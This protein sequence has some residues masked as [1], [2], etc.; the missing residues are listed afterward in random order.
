MVT[1][2]ILI[3]VERSKINEVAE[4]LTE[5]NGISEVY[6]VSGNYDLIAIARVHTNEELSDLV[7]KHMH[8]INSILETETMLAFQAFSRHDLE[9]MFSI[10]SPE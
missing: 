6:S 10:G 8:K 2:F 9:A 1:S 7:T 4:L 5:I 3:N